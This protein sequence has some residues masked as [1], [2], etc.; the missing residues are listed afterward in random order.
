MKVKTYKTR[1]LHEGLEDIKRD[2]GSEALILS[3][4]S[5][6][7]RPPFSLFKKP[8]WEI[9]AAL[10]EKV[11]SKAEPS[12]G[13]THRPLPLG[14]AAEPRVRVTGPTKP[15]TATAVTRDRAPRHSRMDELIAE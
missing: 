12:P 14:E 7:V 1:S 8:A 2:L 5:V 9:T 11:A 6:S 3:T 10:E 15:G 4:R 13:A